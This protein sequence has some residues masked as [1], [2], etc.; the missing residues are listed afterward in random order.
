M[1]GSTDTGGIRTFIVLSRLDDVVLLRLNYLSMLSVRMG[2]GLIIKISCRSVCR[3]TS[4]KW[5][6]MIFFVYLLDISIRRKVHAA[7]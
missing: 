7:R 1:R 4:S 6:F 2:V 5:F 3:C